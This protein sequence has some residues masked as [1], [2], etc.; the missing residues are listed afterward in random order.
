[1]KPRLL[2]I[3]GL[4]PALGLMVDQ[5]SGKEGIKGTFEY[6]D[7]IKIK[8]KLEITIFRI[9]QELINNIIKHSKAKNFSIQISQDQESIKLIVDDDGIGF[10]K[11]RTSPDET[12]LRGMGLISITERVQAFKGNIDIDSSPGNGTVVA[13]EFPANELSA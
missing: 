12:K 6:F 3:H 8:P 4:I 1:M 9:C 2:E 5:V 11:Q 7:E 13:I 10:E